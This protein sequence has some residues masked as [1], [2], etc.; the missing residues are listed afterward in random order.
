[1]LFEKGCAAAGIKRPHVSA[2]KN[3]ARQQ[4]VDRSHRM[5]QHRVMRGI[6][7]RAVELDIQL[8]FLRTVRATVGIRHLVENLRKDRQIFRCGPLRGHEGSKAFDL[9]AKFQIV[10]KGFGAAGEQIN[11]RGRQGRLPVNAATNVP[12]PCL[13]ISRPLSSSV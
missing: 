9:A 6:H 1:M 12:S 7:N 4:L 2:Q 5:H 11:H 10:A 8:Q 3:T 13:T